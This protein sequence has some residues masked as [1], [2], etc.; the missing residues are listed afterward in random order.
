MAYGYR[1][2][3]PY[4]KKIYSK[5][6]KPTTVKKAISTAR[7]SNFNKR[8]MAVLHRTRET[9]MKS[10]NLGDN[11]NIYGQGLTATTQNQ[12]SPARGY[13]VPNILDNINLQQGTDQESRIGNSIENAKLVLSGVV[14]SFAYN[15]SYN[16]HIGPFEVHM[17]IYKKKNDI[18]GE[19]LHIKQIS[20][21]NTTGQC[22][23]T[24]ASTLYPY[25]K[26]E[27]II[28]KVR[29]F[30][31]RGHRDQDTYENQPIV[32]PTGGQD[33]R[34]PIVHRFKQ[35]VPISKK[36][37]FRD[38]SNVPSNSWAT[39]AFYAVDLTG[40]VI[41]TNETRCGVYLDATLTFEDA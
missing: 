3:K 17:V 35:A 37:M 8:V 30:K 26:D 12:G 36:L 28:H 4:K 25:N 39:V 6:K 27:Y 32:D 16:Q 1:A 40:N 7:R 33:S 5:A 19:P 18:N 2:K 10:I 24:L 11:H 13:I 14:R 41:Q 34:T 38:Q 21:T 9:K 31:L 29:V 15:S 20:A 22:D 23:G